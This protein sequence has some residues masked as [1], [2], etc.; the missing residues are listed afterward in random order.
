MRP[1]QGRVLIGVGLAVA[2]V[3][4]LY[5]EFFASTIVVTG[6]TRAFFTATV[7]VQ[8]IALWQANAVR[9]AFDPEDTVRKT[10]TLICV[11][12]TLRCLAELRLTTLYFDLVP[13]LITSSETA[14]FVYKVVLRYLYTVSDLVAIAALLSAIRSY[15]E[16]GLEFELRGTDYAIAGAV[17]LVPV[18]SF[19]L[20]S[21]L[22][23]FLTGEDPTIVTY[24]LVAVSVGAVIAGLSL[25]LFRLV[26]QMGGGMLSKV[27]GSASLAGIA[28]T[29]SFLA[30]AAIS[31]A[32]V[33]VGEFVEQSLLWLFAG[34]WLMAALSQRALLEDG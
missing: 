25:A 34:G 12:L 7:V 13:D 30:L 15:R 11:F 8:I 24:R 4:H 19:V 31:G 3:A 21:N 10:W 18:G 2:L 20:R 32:S 6:L 23:S 29:L 14:F 26:M 22:D 28:R 9:L 17:A 33:T 1:G 5:A 16:A 27:W